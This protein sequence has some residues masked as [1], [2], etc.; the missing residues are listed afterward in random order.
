[1]NL[2]TSRITFLLT[3]LILISG[4]KTKS[5]TQSS[6]L[7]QKVSVSRLVSVPSEFAG[8]TVKLRGCYLRSF[9]VSGLVNS[10]KDLHSGKSRSAIWIGDENPLFENIPTAFI[11]YVEVV[12]N[13]HYDANLG[14]GHMNGYLGSIDNPTEFRVIKYIEV[15]EE[16]HTSE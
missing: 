14:A 5:P 4:C 3:A 2:S 1:M 6:D 16:P 12:G 13:F 15:P 9:E 10:L 7:Y 8:K 11:G